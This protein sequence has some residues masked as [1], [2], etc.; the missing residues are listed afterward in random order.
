M[1]RLRDEP[2]PGRA[3]LA[4]LATDAVVPVPILPQGMSPVEDRAQPL[5]HASCC[6]ASRSCLVFSGA[7]PVR[8]TEFEMARLK[9]RLAD[10]AGAAVLLAARGILRRAMAGAL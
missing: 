5:Q 1:C 7:M 9:L 6:P 3:G 10:E 8:D 2:K 4:Q